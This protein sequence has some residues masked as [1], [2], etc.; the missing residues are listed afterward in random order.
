ML[1]IIYIYGIN[2]DKKY[3]SIVIIALIITAAFLMTY[4]SKGYNYLISCNDQDIHAY[5]YEIV[6]N[7]LY[8]P[9]KVNPKFVCNNYSIIYLKGNN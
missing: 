8:T 4:Y 9:N 2:M 7:L 5:E 6:D 3:L 1:S